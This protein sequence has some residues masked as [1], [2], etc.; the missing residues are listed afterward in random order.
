[1]KEATIDHII[2]LSKG[3]RDDIDNMQLAH[4]ACNQLKAD[5]MPT[6]NNEPEG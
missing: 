6:R 5:N 2:P 1:M 3:G 4:D